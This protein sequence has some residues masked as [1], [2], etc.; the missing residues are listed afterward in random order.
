M[1]AR[2]ATPSAEQSFSHGSE[3]RVHVPTTPQS[4]ATITVN[5]LS[6]QLEV[7][8]QS[9]T[10][11]ANR[12]SETATA[13][14][15]TAGPAAPV[16]LQEMDHSQLAEHLRRSGASADTIGIVLDSKY[17][18]S[19]WVYMMQDSSLNINAVL[20]KDFKI[21]SQI[22]RSRLQRQIAC[23]LAS[24]KPSDPSQ[25]NS[26]RSEEVAQSAAK[27]EMDAKIATG[28][29]NLATEMRKMQA[30]TLEKNTK[31][32]SK[33]VKD[34]AKHMDMP[35]CPAPS[36][37][38]LY[39]SR[40]DWD[41][42]MMATKLHWDAVD[43]KF[44]QLVQAAANPVAAFV[45]EDISISRE[46]AECDT[47]WAAR[48]AN[49]Q[50]GLF[51]HVVTTDSTW[52][53]RDR[54]GE[55]SSALVFINIVS[56]KVSKT[57]SLSSEKAVDKFETVCSDPLTKAS[58]LGTALEQY[59][60]ARKEYRLAKGQYP[61]PETC[62]NKLHRLLRK[63]LIEPDLLLVLTQPYWEYKKRQEETGKAEDPEV[64]FG[65]LTGILH[66][67]KDDPAFK[68]RVRQ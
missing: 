59:A 65:F 23:M 6:S 4:S 53:N 38:S 63:L 22:L 43:L 37:P 31:E 68:A 18:G 58:Q 62:C 5:P 19:E 39:P 1:A 15:T 24:F 20:E 54:A 29:A 34:M 2:D 26:S 55:R 36:P 64:L 49:E 11:D 28:L 51:K 32:Q 41:D 14:P 56:R 44:S 46:E 30:Q 13:P 40:M 42:Y 61:S 67:N 48:L 12:H 35:T 17:C 27:N 16:D 21:E 7:S 3:D 10:F 60:Q 33:I 8:S 9:A 25:G 45:P 66:D 47:C 52:L 57:S 50:K